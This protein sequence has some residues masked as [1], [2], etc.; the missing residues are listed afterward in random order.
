M[1]EL[2]LL[3]LN[4]QLMFQNCK[5]F[6]SSPKFLHG[7]IY[8]YLAPFLSYLIYI[9]IC[10]CVCVCAYHNIWSLAEKK[11]KERKLSFF[12]KEKGTLM[13]IKCYKISFAFLLLQAVHDNKFLSQSILSLGII[14]ICMGFVC[15]VG[16]K[17]KLSLHDC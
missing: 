2:F 1:R 9:Y 5:W 14:C 8:K 4:D 16:E 7:C 17:K 11:K 12:F 13:S 15:Y 3:T 6:L 10:V